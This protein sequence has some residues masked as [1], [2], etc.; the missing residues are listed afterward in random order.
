MERQAVTV[1][2]PADLLERAKRFQLNRESFN[3]LVV[4]AIMREVQR[5]QALAAHERIVARSAE[6]EQQTGVQ[7]SSVDLIRQLREGKERRG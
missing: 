5:R 6:V 2:L 7:A 4:E 1:R 3:E